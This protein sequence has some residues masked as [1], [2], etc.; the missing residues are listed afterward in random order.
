MQITKSLTQKGDTIIEVMM[1]LVILSAV[2]GGTFAVAQRSKTSA[3][4]N[5]ERY[6]AQMYANEQAEWIRQASAANRS[7][8]MGKFS[9]SDTVFCMESSTSVQLDESQPAC[10]K[11]G[12]YKVTVKAVTSCS[13]IT[14]TCS[15]VYNNYY[16]KVSWDSLKGGTDTVELVYGI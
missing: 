16:I 10:T 11:D 4:A 1:A 7:T 14:G 15:N 2:L 12:L 6:Q 9:A 3:Q 5:H 8:F 13:Y